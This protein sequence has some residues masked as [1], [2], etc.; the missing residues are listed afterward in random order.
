MQRPHGTGGE[1]RATPFAE[2]APNLQRG[3]TVHLQGIPRRVLRARPS[4]GVWILQLTGFSNRDEVEV[5]RG[6][7]LEALDGQVAREEGAYFVHE[8]VG[9]RVVTVDGRELGE[10]TEVLQ[11]GANDVYVVKGPAGEVLIPAI[12]EVVT[13]IDLPVSVMHI[14]LMPGL[15]DESK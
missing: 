4:R 5:L 2:G 6:E 7:L 15:L 12:P 11:T 1:L 10:L 9:M 8:L 14:T 13:A 3:R